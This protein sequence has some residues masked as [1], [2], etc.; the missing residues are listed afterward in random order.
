FAIEGVNFDDEDFP[1]EALA[2]DGAI[3]VVGVMPELV[4]GEGAEFTGKW[5]NNEQY[6][7]QFKCEAVMPISPKNKQGIIRYISDTVY[8]IGD[9]TAT[10]IF[11]HFGEDTLDILDNDPERIYDV[12]MLKRNLAEN[13][14][15][16]WSKNR[17]ERQTMIYLQSFGIT[18]RLAK[19]I[20]NSYINGDDPVPMASI[21]QRVKNDPYTLA[22]DIH[23]I[24]FK[25]ADQIALGMGIPA[26]APARLRA[27]IVHTLSQ[28]A[29][30]GHTYAPRSL[31]IQEARV[32]LG[33]DT[34]DEILQSQL[35]E[36]LLAGKLL[37]DHL[38]D[39]DP[40]TET[41][42]IRAIYLPVFYNAEVAV[43]N[44]LRVLANSPSPIITHAQSINDWDSFLSDLADE[45][46][47]DLSAQQQGAV[48]GAMFSKVSVLTGGP[49]TG[50]TTTL[51]MVIN[52]LDAEG[53]QYMLASPTGR[54]A[55]RLGEA[56]ERD[57]STIHRLL[58]FNP[59]FGGFDYDE[60]NPLEAEII[61]IDEAS[62]ID[63]QLFDFLLRAIAPGAH[64]ML[65]GDIDQ[66]PSVGAGNVLNDVINSGIA[67][68]TRLN[69]IFRQDDD[70][71]IIVNAHRINEGEMPYT[72]NES[73]DFFFFNMSDPD[74]AAEMIVD[75][76][77]SRLK[78]V[79]GEYD[80][81]Q[82]VQVI[83]PMYRSGV[84]VN[85]LNELLQETLNPPGRTAE[86]KFGKKVFRVGDKVMQTKNN[87]EKDVFNG[88]IG[89]VRG[90]DDDE[91]TISIWMDGR[92]VDYQYEDADE[93]LIHAYCISTHR[94]QGSEYPVVVMPVMTQHYMM[95][96]RNLLY[97]AITRAKQMV[98]LVGTRKAIFV[99]VENNKVNE[100]Y[101][102]L[103]PRLRMDASRANRTQP[104][105]L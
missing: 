58:G 84:G 21:V 17:A 69:Q 59:A 19:R 96:Q 78:R 68:V 102:G 70:S 57:A 18:S 7:K 39:D 28:L 77:Y 47:I 98:V 29:R 48:T 22:D 6:G 33:V 104:T 49:G 63:L 44:K 76:V 51:K 71:H 13:L 73:K 55:K 95:L 53:Y 75:L 38:P 65:V 90:I 92:I 72:D 10:R 67:H 25:K 43:A 15:E 81:I 86:K 12:P 4:E 46:D 23:G 26:D 32:N 94:S 62:M 41:D 14:L 101:S 40:A 105:L 66:L 89:F 97:T 42:L 35:D 45:S 56:T 54:A 60:S 16:A 99:A 80:P 88:D 50:K 79:L 85:R 24:G 52:A 64:L 82:D 2:Y 20:I 3:A 93:Q 27:G 87:Y 103:L 8:G 34:P 5:V 11:N 36:Q 61:I 74:E 1:E 91:N 31:L 9:V 100:R 83:A 37:S 30:D